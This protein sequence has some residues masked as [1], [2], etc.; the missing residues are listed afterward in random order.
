MFEIEA[1]RL[2]GLS[3]ERA[4]LFGAPHVGCRYTGRTARAYERT[5]RR[6][7]ICGRPAGSCHHVMPLGRADHFDLTTPNGSWRLRSALLC[8]CGTGATG[9]HNGFHAGARFR[10]RWAWDDERFEREWWDGLLLATYGPHSP[11]LYRFGRW[12]VEDRRTGKVWEIR[13]RQ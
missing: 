5:E 2:Q 8:L 6:C 10:A 7:C 4:E 13:R 3:L 11:E 12:E 9:C 1:S